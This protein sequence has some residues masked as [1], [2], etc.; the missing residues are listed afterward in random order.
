[1]LF[2]KKIK[3]QYVFWIFIFPLWTLC[4]SCKDSLV[5]IPPVT[6]PN[7]G[8]SINTEISK[9]DWWNDARYGLFIHYGV[10]SALAGEYI[11]KNTDG[12]SIHFQSLGNK[13]NLEIDSL[14]IG[15]GAG[16]E[17]ILYEASIPRSS[18]RKYATEFTAEKFDPQSIVSLAKRAGMK[19][20]ILT[21]KHH[22]GFCLWNSSA[23]EWNISQSPAG[24]R[25]NNDLIAP[26]AKATRDA[27]LKFGIYFSHVRDWMHTGGIG[28][29]PELGMKE[30]SYTESQK[31]MET[32]TYPMI[33]ELLFRYRPDIFWWDSVNPYEEFAIRCN[34]LVT[35]SSATIIQNDR[36]STLASYQ[37]DFAT[38]EQSMNEN[39]EYDN[40]ELC[41]TMNNSWGY[42]QFDTTW[43]R[44]EYILWCLLRA[45]KLG[46]NLLLNIGPRA[47]GTI[48]KECQ[49]ILTKIGD[50]I[51][52]NAEGVYKTRKS[53][54]HFN[55][56]YGPTTWRK[57]DNIQH[58]YYHIFYW[59]GSGEL[60]L[61]GILNSTEEVELI[62]PANP[63]LT[64]QVEAED[65]VGLHITGLPQKEISDLCTM[66]NIKFKSEP[67][68]KE[69]SREINNTICLDALGA[70]IS[71]VVIDD[72]D[73][74]PCINWYLGKPLNYH[75]QITNGG[76]YKISALLAGFYPGTITFDFGKGI[77]LTGNNKPTPGG[78]SGFEY[79]YMG[80]VYLEPG[81]YNLCITCKQTDSWL[82][83][84]EF[85]LVRQI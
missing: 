74:K 21:A 65:G 13:N 19:Y 2:Y 38:P 43:K 83:I 52:I 7:N 44:P 72:F 57:I 55:L 75:I 58:L 47:D 46:G 29:I 15:A 8:D 67:K 9:M 53:P 48:P 76:I 10:Y 4:I 11:G 49:N 23:T 62:F 71:E 14:K 77:T 33:S 35:N 50:W 54:L 84:R 6:G 36:L 66:L 79:E 5:A 34:S 3:Y 20:I 37:G 1:M 31:Y 45:N 17:W 27:G 60:W 85:R 39:T 59:D 70:Q 18:Y 78:L 56:P 24:A 16:A 64:F 63:Q 82:K 22:D 12:V 30:Y 41:M 32:Y 42:N 73:T 40:M 69:G 81:V 26:L 28:H 68:L 61:P 80:D 51:N 25:W